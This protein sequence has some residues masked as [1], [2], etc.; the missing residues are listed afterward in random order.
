MKQ[1]ALLMSE[2]ESDFDE[3]PPHYTSIDNICIPP[4]Y[5]EAAA[6]GTSIYD[7]VADVKKV[8]L[9]DASADGQGEADGDLMVDLPPTPCGMS[10][11]SEINLC[12][13]QQPADGVSEAYSNNLY[14]VQ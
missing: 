4:P 14:G 1:T 6:M 3:D 13:P 7:E 11:S 9:E 10:T 2:Q 8:R 12:L 5:T